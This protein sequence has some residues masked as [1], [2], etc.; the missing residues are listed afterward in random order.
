M[1]ALIYEIISAAATIDAAGSRILKPFGLTPMTFNILNVLKDGPLSQREIGDQI[2]VA[3]SSITFQVRQLQKK[4]LIHRR[5]SDARTWRVSLTPVGAAKRQLA[6]QHMD[7]IIGQI[8]MDPEAIA[9][10]QSAVKEVHRRLADLT[11]GLGQAGI[12][13]K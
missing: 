9:A 6:E 1:K 5:R 12:D 13:S 2:I 11:E 3:A 7:A 8:R 10:A 4:G